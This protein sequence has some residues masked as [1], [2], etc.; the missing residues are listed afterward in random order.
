MTIIGAE[1]WKL[2]LG[3]QH[4]VSS[5]P[6]LP[7]LH[8]PFFART[9]SS[10]L[11][12]LQPRHGLGSICINTIWCRKCFW[13]EH[14]HQCTQ[15]KRFDGENCKTKAEFD[16]CS[17]PTS[18]SSRLLKPRST[19]GVNAHADND[20][21]HLLVETRN[22]L[23]CCLRFGLRLDM[24]KL[25]NGNCVPSRFYR[26]ARVLCDC[27]C[28]LWLTVCQIS[29][30]WAFYSKCCGHWSYHWIVMCVCVCVCVCVCA[31]AYRVNCRYLPENTPVKCRYH[32][33]CR[34][35]QL[36]F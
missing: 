21:T 14:L 34:H 3:V 24:L 12:I 1:F 22:A 4:A 7:P 9:L 5:T 19:H 36:T 30:G 28:Y 6:F 33:N 35:R 18:F 25:I 20:K 17:T 13:W 15:T 23:W 2:Q 11:P 8:S 27:Q 32:V 16:G 31:L 29:S 26:T 10:F